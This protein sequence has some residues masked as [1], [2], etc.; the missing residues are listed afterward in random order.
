[1]SCWSPTKYRKEENFLCTQRNMARNFEN[2][3]R[4][5]QIQETK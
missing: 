1:M 5:T 4:R 2:L 3:T